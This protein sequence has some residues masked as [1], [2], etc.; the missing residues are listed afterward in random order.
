MRRG[1][2]GGGGTAGLCW[3]RVAVA[4]G[5]SR[6]KNGQNRSI[7]DRVMVIFGIFF[8]FWLCGSGS[9][10]VAVEEKLAK[11]ELYL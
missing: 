2:G 7:I 6:A 3:V 9:G 1:C 4:G 8:W 10:W 11:K 5:G